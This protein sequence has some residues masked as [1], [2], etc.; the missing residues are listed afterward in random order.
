MNILLKKQ[1]LLSYKSSYIFKGNEGQ[2]ENCTKKIFY[3][4]IQHLYV[5]KYK[6]KQNP[7]EKISGCLRT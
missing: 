4:E 1:L 5:K 7:F 2:I 3:V 6:F